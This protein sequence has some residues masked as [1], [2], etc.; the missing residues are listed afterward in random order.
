[1]IGIKIPPPP[2]VPPFFGL[3]P[4]NPGEV[5]PRGSL[6]SDNNQEKHAVNASSPLSADSPIGEGSVRSI[7]AS[8]VKLA[9]ADESI[10][11]DE[12]YGRMMLKAK[13]KDLR[14]QGF[15]CICT[16]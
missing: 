5:I 4:S 8:G 3:R 9:A 2:N 13:G 12:P 14:A 11:Q 10:D 16:R 6:P 7:L 15:F 1:M